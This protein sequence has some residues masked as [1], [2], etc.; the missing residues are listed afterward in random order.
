MPKGIPKNGIS[1]GNYSSLA[2]WA[3]EHPGGPWLGK[4]RTKEDRDK[5]SIGSKGKN[6]GR[7]HTKESRNKMSISKLGDKNPSK[8]LD[9]RQRISNS[10]KKFMTNPDNRMRAGLANLGR[11][12]SFESREKIS[13]GQRGERSYSWKGGVSK[14]SRIIRRSFKYRQWR[15]DVFTRDNFTCQDCEKRG[16]Y[17]EAHHIK[18]FS[19]ILEEYSIK[20]IEDAFSCEELWNINNG[21]T[22]CRICHNKTK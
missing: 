3:K 22:L 10:M 13:M 9:V 16:V 20:T 4:K 2:K 6:L 11:K 7:K 5:M 8:R 21:S 14:I 15:S 19:V 18:M 17:L 12:H 1:K